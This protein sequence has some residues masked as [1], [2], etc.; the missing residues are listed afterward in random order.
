MALSPKSNS[1]YLALDAALHDIRKGNTGNVPN[2]IKT[3]SKDYKYGHST[4][5]ATL[6]TNSK[7][8]H[9]CDGCRHVGIGRYFGKNRKVRK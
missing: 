6:G 3:N 1:A 8:S 7:Q 5:Y 4:K 2:H 9:F